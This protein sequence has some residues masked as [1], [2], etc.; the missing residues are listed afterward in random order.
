MQLDLSDIELENLSEQEMA[1]I[2]TYLNTLE[3]GF[4]VSVDDVNQGL[5]NVVEAIPAAENA[6]L[7][8]ESATLYEVVIGWVQLAADSLLAL[9]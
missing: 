5:Q 7:M 3:P 9:I 8:A 6:D 4:G 1:E 2:A